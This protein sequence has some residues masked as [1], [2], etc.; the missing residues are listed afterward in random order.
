MNLLIFLMIKNNS[1][2]AQ[3]L[4]VQKLISSKMRLSCALHAYQKICHYTKTAKS[5]IHFIL[6]YYI[7]F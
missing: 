3:L 4:V 2:N 1:T 7:A 5:Q 6:K